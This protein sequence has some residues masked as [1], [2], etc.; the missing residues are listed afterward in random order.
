MTAEAQTT[1]LSWIF[2]GM[3][4]IGAYCLLVAPFLLVFHGVRKLKTPKPPK[5]ENLYERWGL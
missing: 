2:A 1:L 4:V 5:K 3:A